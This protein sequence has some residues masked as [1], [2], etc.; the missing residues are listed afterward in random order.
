MKL[1]RSS[2]AWGTLIFAFSPVI[3]VEGYS[4]TKKSSKKSSKKSNSFP[5]T[6]YGDKDELGDG[7]IRTF[8]K[9]ANYK[10]LQLGVIFQE[11]LFDNLPQEVSDGA[12]DIENCDPY[13]DTWFCW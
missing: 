8:V 6:D 3:F 12:Y 10:P 2:V 9:H 1:D 4:S 11:S 5:L 7:L 13:M